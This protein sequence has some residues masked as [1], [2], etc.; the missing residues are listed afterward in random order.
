MQLTQKIRLEQ[1]GRSI[2]NAL[3]DIIPSVI[4]AFFVVECLKEFLK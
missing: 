1:K 2:E 4:F 3:K